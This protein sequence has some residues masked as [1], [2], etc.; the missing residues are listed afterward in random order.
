MSAQCNIKINIMNEFSIINTF[1]LL[2]IFFFFTFSLLII[3]CIT[4]NMLSFLFLY[5][6]I[7]IG[8]NHLWCMV[9]INFRFGIFFFFFVHFYHSQVHATI[10]R[11][12]L[13]LHD[14]DIS[15]RQACRVFFFFLSCLFSLG[16]RPVGD[17]LT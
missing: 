13:H 12:V 8:G 1:C 4:K 7:P 9:D 10:P 6:F 2:N 16:M 15:V 5:T 17:S 11:L 3:S 14:D